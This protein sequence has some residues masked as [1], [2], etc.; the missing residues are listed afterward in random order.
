MAAPIPGL[1]PALLS[2]DLHRDLTELKGFRHLVRHRYGIE[3]SGSKVLENVERMQ[4]AF[5]SFV[6]ALLDLE[7]DLTRYLGDADELGN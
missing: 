6:D 7:R 1:R 4:R 3:L 5:P 2:A